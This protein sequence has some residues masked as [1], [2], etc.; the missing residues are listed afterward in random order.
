LKAD[1]FS[2]NGQHVALLSRKRTCL[3]YPRIYLVPASERPIEKILRKFQTHQRLTY[4]GRW[5]GNARQLAA[6]RSTAE[7]RHKNRKNWITRD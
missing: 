3:T 1:I 6:F 4:N 2:R 5:Q 7:T